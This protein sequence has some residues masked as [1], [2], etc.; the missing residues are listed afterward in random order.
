MSNG[1]LGG[2]IVT[3]ARLSCCVTNN[4]QATM[5]HVCIPSQPRQTMSSHPPVSCTLLEGCLLSVLSFSPET[6]SQTYRL[7]LFVLKEGAFQPLPLTLTHMNLPF[8]VSLGITNT[9]AKMQ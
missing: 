2:L 6:K 8:H 7:F 5:E 1:I 4:M 9:M 3:D